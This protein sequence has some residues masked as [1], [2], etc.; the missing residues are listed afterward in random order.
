MQHFTY[1]WRRLWRY[2]FGHTQRW[3]E[4]GHQMREVVL[5][6]RCWKLETPQARE[7]Y[8]WSKFHHENVLELLGVANFQDRI[9]MV[10]PWMDNGALPNY[11]AQRRNVDRYLICLQITNGLTYLHDMG[12]VHGDIKGFNILV[13]KDGTAK[14]AD[15][16][17]TLLNE[18]TLQFTDTTSSSGLSTRWTA[19]ELLEGRT[20]RSF[21]ADVYALGMTILEVITGLP[22]YHDKSDSAVMYAVGIKRA[23]PPRPD[24][25]PATTQRGNALWALLLRCWA[26]EPEARLKAREVLDAMKDMQVRVYRRNGRVYV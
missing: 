22:P 24:T 8:T 12:T 3:L 5:W 13:S 19:P 18:Y 11:I 17:N 9:A 4:C 10:S 6:L 7:L 14:I 2:L 1:R 26:Y 15:F 25:I 16:G 21:E 20:P 23:H